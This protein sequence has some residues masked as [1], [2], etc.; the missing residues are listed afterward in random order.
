MD[1]S[2]D[3][4]PIRGSPYLAAPLAVRV[5]VAEHIEVVLGYHVIFTAYGFWLPNEPRGAW[6]EFVGTWELFLHGR[7]TKTTSKN[8]LA[9]VA[10]DPSRRRAAKLALSRSPVRFTGAQA[11]SI[12][13]GFRKAGRDAGYV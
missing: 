12:G 1:I 8:S 6:S 5:I 9:S 3:A 4:A 10:H 7:A 11:R 13:R 2:M